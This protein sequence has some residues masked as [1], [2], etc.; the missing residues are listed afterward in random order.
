MILNTKKEREKNSLYTTFPDYVIFIDK[1]EV[2]EIIN[3]EYI[4]I[5]NINVATELI[6]KLLTNKYYFNYLYKYFNND[7][8]AFY[9]QYMSHFNPLINFKYDKKTIIDSIEYLIN[10]KK[11]IL[12]EKEK[13]RYKLLKKLLKQEED[14]Y[15]NELQKTFKDEILTFKVDKTTYNYE[16]EKLIEILKLNQK[17]FITYLRDFKDIKTEHYIYIIKDFINQIE[18]INN[19]NLPYIIL[20]K[21]NWIENTEEYDL[22][23]INFITEIDNDNLKKVN[24]DKN[25]IYEL[26]KDI[27]KDYT[28]LEQAIYVYIKMCKL[29]KYDH[30]F[31][32]A[33]NN[34][35]QKQQKRKLEHV[36]SVNMIN[37]TIICYEFTLIYSKI[38]SLLNINHIISQPAESYGLGHD[39]ITLRVDKFLVNVDA[40]TSI[41]RGDIVKAKLNDDLNGINCINQNQNT[42]KEFKTLVNNVY[43]YLRKDEKTQ[44]I[45]N[46]D[47]NLTFKEKLSLFFSEI[48]KQDL[49]NIEL[50][51]FTIILKDKIFNKDELTNNIK[52]AI[53]KQNKNDIVAVITI[54]DTNYNSNEEEN[55]YCIISNNNIEII[56]NEQLQERFE[57]KKITYIEEKTIVLI[58][59]LRVNRGKIKT[60]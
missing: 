8:E 43:N 31:Y 54:N 24:I 30:T 42:Q 18:I 47:E 34:D 44:L 13:K 27:P 56:N 14:K 7:I 25:L 55:I 39:Y 1:D 10:N 5:N 23:A 19:Y 48:K 60:K 15:F 57:T 29:L 9:I 21:I 35:Y 40:V 4:Q 2:D 59:G 12:N 51:G 50:L 58:P 45:E 52:L 28:K 16:A 20:D 17:E 11:L 41:F 33:D 6:K 53:M 46:I 26:I 37:K 32:V 36:E 22:E 38:L 49:E 3:K